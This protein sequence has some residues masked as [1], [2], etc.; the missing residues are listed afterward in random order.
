MVKDVYERRVKRDIDE[1]IYKKEVR[2][3]RILSSVK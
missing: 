2:G 1:G 3:V